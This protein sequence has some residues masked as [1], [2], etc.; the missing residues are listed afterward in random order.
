MSG[1]ITTEEH[2]SVMRRNH[3]LTL[4]LRSA[5]EDIMRAR[6]DTMQAEKATRDLAAWAYHQLQRHKRELAEASNAKKSCEVYKEWN[7]KKRHKQDVQVLNTAWLNFVETLI[8]LREEPRR[9][10]GQTQEG[11]ENKTGSC[12]DEDAG[13][14]PPGADSLPSITDQVEELIAEEKD[15]L[16]MVM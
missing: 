9:G 8:V 12:V 2:E 5:R 13:Y 1:Y 16:P 6:E 3:Q 10:D 4:E 7:N 15:R 14:S 11:K